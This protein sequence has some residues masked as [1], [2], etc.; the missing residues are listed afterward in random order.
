MRSRFS[1]ILLGLFLLVSTLVVAQS[2][3]YVILSKLQGKG[4]TNF[5]TSVTAAGGA[6][7]ANY[8]AIGVVLAT[9]SNPN[10]AA[11]LAANS[12]VQNVAEDM[13]V[14]WVP[15]EPVVEAGGI[16]AEGVNS[17]P[18][19][20]YLWNIR[21]IHANVTAA[22]GDLGQGARVVIFDSGLD[23]ANLDLAPNINAALSHSF[24][25]GEG[26]QPTCGGASRCF[27]H[28]THVAGIIAA[29]I[30]NRGVQGVAPEAEVISV[31]VLRESGSGSFSWLIEGIE[32]ATTLNADVGNMSLGAT[33]PRVNAGGGG[34][35]PL[36]AALDRALNHAT[37]AGI[38]MVSSAGNDASNLN[39]PAYNPDVCGSEKP[40]S[41]WSIPAQLG[42][43]IAV[44]ATG[45]IALQNFDRLASYSNY[46]ESVVNVAAPGGD[47][48]LYPASNY[49]IDMVLSDSVGAYYFA[50]G[51]S[52]AAP[53]VTGVAALIVG[54]Y[55]HMPPAQL[56][57]RIQ[58]TAVDI[59]KPGADPQSGQG[60]V[61]AA[62]ALQ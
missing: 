49:Y 36:I 52:M 24:V 29:A 18:Y 41:L 60:R 5:L 47:F 58:Q 50:A 34:L 43:G 25:P 53:H 7:T 9:S 6:V 30:N 15:K 57:T 55:G 10:F 26:V 40:C 17:E 23:L 46:G 4:S 45:P 19:N 21:Q 38:L 3:D 31:K 8:E 22:N 32:Y 1:W 54:K 44:S 39:A 33:F 14:Q 2:R 48:T 20:G 61:D 37:Q 62:A 28:G 35:G 27:N 42:N 59:L 11:Q 12:N 51:T 13:E 16:V 56:K